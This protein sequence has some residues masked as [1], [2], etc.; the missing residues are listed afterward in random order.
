L[1]P[2]IVISFFLTPVY[3]F[4]VKICPPTIG[5][6]L[7]KPIYLADRSE[8][9][10][11]TALSF[12]EKEQVRIISRFPQMLDNVRTGISEDFVDYNIIHSSNLSLFNEIGFYMRSIL[13][14][15]FPENSN[16]RFILI[17]NRQNIIHNI[18]ENIYNLIDFLKNPLNSQIYDSLVDNKVIDL[19]N[20]NLRYFKVIA[21]MKEPVDIDLFI[22]ISGD[23]SPMMVNLRKL[24]ENPETVQYKDYQNQLIDIT[25]LF[26][27]T[28]LLEMRWIEL[29]RVE[30]K[31]LK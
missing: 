31:R 9:D 15:S 7:S 10:T 1:I 30:M 17:Q 19:L 8:F 23:K 21:S 27:S 29:L 25:N 5:E 20:V 11:E 28:N 3:N 24:Y 26:Y 2:T 12:V 14:M 16:E 13:E 6:E 18:E 22:S 4:I